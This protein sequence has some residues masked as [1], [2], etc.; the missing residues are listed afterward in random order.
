MGGAGGKRLE[1][2]S[3]LDYN[4]AAREGLR[5]TGN[6]KQTGAESWVEDAHGDA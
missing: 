2:W 4:G 3:N 1:P 6:R 5:A